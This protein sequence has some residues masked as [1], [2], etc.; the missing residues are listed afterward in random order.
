MLRFL[1]ILFILS[2]PCMAI[3]QDFAFGFK[4]GLTVGFQKWNNYERTP[5]PSYN[6]SIFIESLG[7]EG[8]FATFGQLGYHVKGSRLRYYYRHSSGELKRRHHDTEFRNL[9][10]I[11]GIKKSH[12]LN[13]KQLLGYYLLGVRGDYNLNYRLDVQSNAFLEEDVNKITYGLTLGG[14]FQFPI[15]PLIGATL[16]F[17]VSPDIRP[18]IYYPKGKYKYTNHLGVLTPVNET[19]VI[20]TVFEVTLGLRFLRLVEFMDEE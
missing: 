17:Q 9:S 13:S 12:V 6:G 19:K 10:L 8:L 5:L 2:L 18:Q 11:L 1:V 14:G 20:N 4:G 15:S 3:S 16:E 7:N